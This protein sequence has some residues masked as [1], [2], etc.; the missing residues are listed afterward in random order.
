MTNNVTSIF[1]TLATM[2]SWTYEQIINRRVRAFHEVQ[3]ITEEEFNDAYKDGYNRFMNTS[4]AILY[5][6]AIESERINDAIHR[7]QEKQQ[8]EAQ[9][10]AE[11]EQAKAKEDETVDEPEEK[12][13]DE[14]GV[15]VSAAVKR[16]Q[17]Q[18]K[19]GDQ[20]GN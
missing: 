14:D 8:A 16:R 4:F 11:A 5:D 19:N 2:E 12:I 15:K 13:V 3:G 18:N 7:L 1:P 17:E 20:D 6:R 9:K 10:R